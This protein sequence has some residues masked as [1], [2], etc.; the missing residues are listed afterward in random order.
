MTKTIFQL[1][2][3]F[4]LLGITATSCEPQ[5]NKD[6]I[7]QQIL[8]NGQSIR[9]AFAKGD[10]EKIKALH[11]PDVEKAL[12]YSNVQKGREEVIKGIEETLENYY[13]IFIKNEVESILIQDG[14]AIEQSRFSIKG[15]PKKGGEPFVFSGRS[16]VTYVRYEK[17]PTGWASIREII[18]VAT[19]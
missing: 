18:Q 2:F 11:H 16:M 17:S 19:E 4:V 14:L 10:I 15:T 6:A 5:V 7:R 1:L 12:A 3:L 13:L 9:D 8:D